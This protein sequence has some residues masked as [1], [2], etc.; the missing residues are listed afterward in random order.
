MTDTP[1]QITIAILLQ[2]KINIFFLFNYLLPPFQRHN[3]RSSAR[4]KLTLF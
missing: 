1:K 4:E 2:T 3:N